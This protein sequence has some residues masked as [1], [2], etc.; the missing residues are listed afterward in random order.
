[1]RA[2]VPFAVLTVAALTI[3]VP[4]EAAGKASASAATVKTSIVGVKVP[5]TGRP[6][7]APAAGQPAAPAP[8]LFKA[9]M[10]PFVIA[11]PEPPKPQAPPPPP[12]VDLPLP[13]E[14]GIPRKAAPAFQPLN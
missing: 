12:G 8:Q 11:R 6:G 2:F 14:V 4:V 1:M 3:S 9:G 13:S 5:A 10:R 7:A